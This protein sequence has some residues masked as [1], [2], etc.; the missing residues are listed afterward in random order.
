[1]AQDAILHADNNHKTTGP[2]LWKIRPPL[3]LKT[4][5]L[6]KKRPPLTEKTTPGGRGVSKLGFLHKKETHTLRCGFFFLADDVGLEP[7]KCKA[8]VE[9]CLPPAYAAATP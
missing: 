6:E 3:G 2:P 9:P 7:I 4:T 5:P 1:M 8:P